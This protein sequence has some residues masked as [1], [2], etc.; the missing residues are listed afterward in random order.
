[1]SSLKIFLIGVLA[2]FLIGLT[3]NCKLFKAENP[4]GP[5]I[6]DIINE[7]NG[8][9]NYPAMGQ[10]G[11]EILSCYFKITLKS[12]VVQETVC[13]DQYTAQGKYIIGDVEITNIGTE[14]RVG[15][16]NAMPIFICYRLFEIRDN[17]GN[18]YDI[19]FFLYDYQIR[20]CL[21]GALASKDCALYLPNQ[22]VSGKI[23]FDVPKDATGLILVFYSGETEN[24]IEFDLGL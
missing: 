10:V 12:V 1:M 8:C 21:P 6:D 7:G 19:D 23:I 3:F 15:A 18:T 4:A 16:D 13:D 22:G 24:T 5:D 17:K 20:Q 11:D 2:I 14:Q 9:S